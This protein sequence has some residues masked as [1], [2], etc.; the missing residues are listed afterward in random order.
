MLARKRL[1]NPG[2]ALV[3]TASDNGYQPAMIRS[4]PAS[5]ERGLSLRFRNNSQN[6]S[7]NPNCT[8][9]PGAA[10]VTVPNARLL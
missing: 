2:C 1:S 9:R 8:L 5:F 7:F 3:P 10:P 6:V 4:A